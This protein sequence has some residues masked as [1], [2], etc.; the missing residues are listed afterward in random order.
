MS[1][2]KINDVKFEFDPFA[3]GNIKWPFSKMEVGQSMFVAGGESTQT[4]IGGKAYRAAQ[5]V[6]GYKSWKFVGEQVA[7]GIRIWRVK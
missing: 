1:F 7:S 2:A 6:G 3:P 4:G 5:R